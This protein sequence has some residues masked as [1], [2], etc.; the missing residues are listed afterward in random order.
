MKHNIIGKKSFNKE[1]K[2]VLGD[3][4]VAGMVQDSGMKDSTTL[5]TQTSK[6]MEASEH[7][8]NERISVNNA[9]NIINKDS[10]NNA[11]EQ[12]TELTKDKKH[13]SQ[14]NSLIEHNDIIPQSLNDFPL[15]SGI[16]SSNDHQ[17]NSNNDLQNDI[18]DKGVSG[19]TSI[20]A[21]L[22]G[23][24]QNLINNE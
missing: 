6:S 4:N 22:L 21:Y 12:L 2:G 23:K 14:I 15:P 9:D 11:E 10:N 5:P 24:N 1:E 19:T 3:A 7:N 16:S 18:R 13:K 8:E 20:P 17:I